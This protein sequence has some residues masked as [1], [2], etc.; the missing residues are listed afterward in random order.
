MSSSPS[1]SSSP[2]LQ[3]VPVITLACLTVV[4]FSLPCTALAFIVGCISI[5][6]AAFDYCLEVFGWRRPSGLYVKKAF[7]GFRVLDLGSFL[8]TLCLDID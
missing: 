8:L 1:P 3:D 5:A 7:V 4:C 2:P 6:S